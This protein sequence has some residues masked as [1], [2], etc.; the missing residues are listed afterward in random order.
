MTI[1]STILAT[2]AASLALGASVAAAADYGPVYAGMLSPAPEIV[3][4]EVGTGWYLRGDVEYGFDS[5]YDGSASYSIFGTDF[6][7][8]YTD[9]GLDEGF[10]G[11][12]GVGYQ[13][14]DYLRGDLTARYSKFD[15]G[16][17]SDF[18][19]FGAGP[20]SFGASAEARSWDLMANAYVDLGTFAGFTPYVGGGLGAVNV[21]YEDVSTVGCEGDPA[22]CTTTSF[23]GDD[24]WRFAYA[25]MA[26]VGYN[27]NRSLTLDIGYRY[28]NIDGGDVASFTSSDPIDPSIFAEDDGYD[29]HIITAGL[30]YK[31]W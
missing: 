15:V 22:F 3:P 11:G 9:F 10:G 23:D 1:R 2:L 19:C 16:A 20:C 13:L 30:R 4:V 24:S 21:S 14:T 26:G 31:L 12:L 7:P 8:A 25:L 17:A 18:E 28:L 29:R 6:G 5:D 27:L